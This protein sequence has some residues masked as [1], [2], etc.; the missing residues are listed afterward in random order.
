MRQIYLDYNATTPIAPSVFEAMRPFLMEHFGNPSSQH[1]LGIAAHQ[2]VEDARQCVADAL[3][4]CT[5]E[6]F[7]TSG[8]TESNN[9]AMLGMAAGQQGYRGHL[10][11]S[12]VEHPAVTAPARFLERCGCDVTVIATDRLR[13]C[14]RGRRRG[15]DSRG[16]RAGQ[17]DAREQ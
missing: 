14:R 4:A 8:G 3:G 1:A 15:G 9:L 16:H 5:D 17:R 13:S 10:I 2:A 11:I 12:A 7:F 6:V